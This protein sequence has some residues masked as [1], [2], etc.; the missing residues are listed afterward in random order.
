MF[1]HRLF[2]HLGIVAALVV[3]IGSM[4]VLLHGRERLQP[5]QQATESSQLEAVSQMVFSQ[6]DTA[7]HR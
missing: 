7:L 1:S 3:L 6:T 4:S 5:S 2:A